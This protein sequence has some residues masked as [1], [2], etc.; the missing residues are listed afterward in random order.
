MATE[1]PRSRAIVIVDVEDGEISWV[2]AVVLGNVTARLRK[3]AFAPVLPSRVS[4]VKVIEKTLLETVAVQSGV[5][6][7]LVGASHGQGGQ[8]EKRS[9]EQHDGS[10]TIELGCTVRTSTEHQLVRGL[11]IYTILH[12]HVSC[13]RQ[14][15][16]VKVSDAKRLVSHSRDQV[17][18]YVTRLPYASE[19]NIVKTNLFPSYCMQILATSGISG[20]SRMTAFKL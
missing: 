18:C 2:E 15:S 12:R 10:E 19:S 7:R 9:F 8:R 5:H 6:L 20:T 16:Q 14:R 11:R 13:K 17:H 3:P 4:R 1:R